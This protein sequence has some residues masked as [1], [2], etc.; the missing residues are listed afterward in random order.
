VPEI[1]YEDYAADKG[2]GRAEIASI[3]REARP[4]AWLVNGY[5]YSPGLHEYA[6]LV[7]LL[8]DARVPVPPQGAFVQV[9]GR[10]DPRATGYKFLHV[11]SAGVVEPQR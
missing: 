4:G 7:W 8:G 2:F 3:L 11:Q 10:Q 9:C 6:R 1:R 5:D